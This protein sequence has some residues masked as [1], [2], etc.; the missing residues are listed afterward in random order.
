MSESKIESATYSSTTVERHSSPVICDQLNNDD[1]FH[2]LG[3][4]SYSDTDLSSQYKQQ[5]YVEESYSPAAVDGICNTFKNLQ[6]T[7][8]SL[9]TNALDQLVQQNVSLDT[10]QYPLNID[11]CPEHV[12]R[13]NNNRITYKQD[14]SV[15]YLQPVTPPPPGPLIIREIRAAQLPEAPPLVIRQRP[16]VPMTP[17]PLI[18]RERPPLPPP[19]VQSRVVNKYIAAPPP[20]PRRVIIER[21]A[22]LP[23]KPQ[24]IIIE[25]WLPYRTPPKQRVIVQPAPPLIPR[26]PQ[27]N[28][29]VTY[30]APH[31]DVVKKVHDLGIVRVNPHVYAAH[32]GSQLAANEYVLNTMA[33]FGIG[34]NYMKMIQMQAM[35]QHFNNHQSTIYDQ[36]SSVNTYIPPSLDNYHYLTKRVEEIILPD[37]SRKRRSSVSGSD[38]QEVQRQ[39]SIV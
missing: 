32:Y 12:R 24:P 34:N 25:K 11:H 39:A 33:K 22:P 9:S 31:V 20:P 1:V 19:V 4:L 21:Q 23:Q 10:S 7:Q 35:N 28:T 30:D 8:R 14:V 36:C 6:T 17:P 27:K 15:R 5:Q 38:E 26:P 3:T 18:I 29:I 2:S 16:P 13:H 37:G